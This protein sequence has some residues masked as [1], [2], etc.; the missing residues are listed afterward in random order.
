M[1]HDISLPFLSPRA[2]I[3]DVLFFL[4]LDRQHLGL[5][6]KNLHVRPDDAWNNVAVESPGS[7]P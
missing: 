3:L 6:L 2:R 4:L 7:V 5:V 1:A